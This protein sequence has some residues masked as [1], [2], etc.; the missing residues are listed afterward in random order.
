MNI[1]DMGPAET[2]EMYNAFLRRDRAVP[3][4]VLAR[5][6]AF[7]IIPSDLPFPSHTA[8]EEDVAKQ[9]MEEL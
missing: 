5:L 2:V 9:L 6:E 8:G 4:D 7:G 1:L 3:V